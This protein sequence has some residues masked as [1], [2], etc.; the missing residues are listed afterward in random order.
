MNNH[1]FATKDGVESA[2]AGAILGWK[3]L[4]EKTYHLPDAE[5]SKTSHYR[6]AKLDDLWTDGYVPEAAKVE[7]LMF[8]L[9]TYRLP[10]GRP[11][12]LWVME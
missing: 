4:V 11:V 2:I 7:Y 1:T 12:R 10:N 6:A 5:G 3:A 8:V 9:Q